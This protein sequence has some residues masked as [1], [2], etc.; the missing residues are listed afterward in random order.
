MNECR[1]NQ[2][3][4]HPKARK[5]C[6]WEV[7]GS[8]L[9]LTDSEER[10]ASHPRQPFGTIILILHKA[11]ASAEKRYIA[12]ARNVHNNVEVLFEDLQV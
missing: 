5:A 8:R 2:K 6:G 7:A 3:K 4:M 9:Y 1:R 11:P 12:C 10:N